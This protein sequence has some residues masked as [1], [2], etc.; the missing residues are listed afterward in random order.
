MAELQAENEKLKMSFGGGGGGHNAMVGGG[1]HN[2]SSSS[3]NHNSN[4]NNTTIIS[5]NTNSLP[6]LGEIGVGSQT[7]C[8][9]MLLAGTAGSHIDATLPAEVADLVRPLLLSKSDHPVVN[10]GSN[11][12]AAVAV[13]TGSSNNQAATK[14]T[15]GCDVM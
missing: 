13:G 1:N 11:A 8:L 2:S 5:N 15:I 12:D 6:T 9:Q 3:S 4:N 10:D 14:G 7:I